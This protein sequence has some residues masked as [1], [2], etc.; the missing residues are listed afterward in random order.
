MKSPPASENSFQKRLQRLTQPHFAQQRQ[1]E[2]S[3]QKCAGGND[4]EN[5]HKNTSFSM[6][7]RRGQASQRPWRAASTC[8]LTRAGRARH[9]WAGAP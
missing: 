2:H 6:S 7:C 8:S 1:R 5:E 3:G 9:D 4:K